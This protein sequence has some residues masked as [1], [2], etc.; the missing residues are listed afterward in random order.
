[1]TDYLVDLEPN[2]HIVAEVRR[3][4]FVFYTRIMGLVVIALLPLIFVTPI[5]HF[6][7]RV[8]SSGSLPLFF[9]LYLLWFLLCWIMFFFQWTD[10]YLDVWVITNERI[11]DVEQRGMFS[12]NTSVFT[13]EHVQDITVEVNGLIAT[14]LKYGDVH[15]HTAG[16]SVD[17]I[18]RNAANPLHI[19]KVI[20][21]EHG[22]MMRQ[23]R[24]SEQV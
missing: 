15:I 6:F 22:K 17:F 1:M 20:M 9:I 5:V 19:K 12:R 7:G 23:H 2:E 11:F 4:M 18:I 3:H 14:F 16:E 8:V 13:L 10:Y 21:D 24:A